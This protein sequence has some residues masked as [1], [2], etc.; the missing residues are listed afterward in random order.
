ML[1]HRTDNRLDV[2]ELL[3]VDLDV[4]QPF[5][6]PAQ[7]TSKVTHQS[8]PCFSLDQLFDEI[9]ER[10]GCITN[11]ALKLFRGILVHL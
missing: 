5:I 9:I 1:R 4:F 6:L 8:G 3:L 7:V 11:F 2:I 10:E